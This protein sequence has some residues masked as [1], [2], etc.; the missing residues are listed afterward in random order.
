MRHEALCAVERG[1][2]VVPVARP[3][4]NPRWVPESAVA[5]GG[6]PVPWPGIEGLC[7]AGDVSAFWDEWPN[8]QVALQTGGKSPV[9]LVCR[10]TV[11]PADELARDQIVQR[12]GRPPDVATA[13]GELHFYFAD[14]DKHP[15]A[16]GI[17]ASRIELRAAGALVLLPP[18]LDLWGNPHVWES[19]E[20]S[21]EAV[22]EWLRD[23]VIV[24]I[25]SGK[26]SRTSS[27]T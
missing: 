19:S 9:V 5:V 13:L 21:L 20:L 1:W 6:A 12:V 4:L 26:D 11:E 2:T 25:T 8:A 27:S 3:I 16:S 18:S 22:P 14:D 7:D 10:P 23:S 15:A 17:V 24:D